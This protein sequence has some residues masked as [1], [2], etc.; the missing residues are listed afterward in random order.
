MIWNHSGRPSGLASTTATEAR[1]ADIKRA[2]RI[3]RSETSFAGNSDTYTESFTPIPTK[4]TR[5]EL[6]RKM[7]E[8]EFAEFLS[9]TFCHGYGK[10]GIEVWLLQ[11]VE[12]A[13]E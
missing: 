3:D 2:A 11:E 7:S 5:M 1:L 9:K 4:L 10:A 6:I 8:K 12:R 13:D